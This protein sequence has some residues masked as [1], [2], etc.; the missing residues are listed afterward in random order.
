MEKTFAV[1]A[2]MLLL[3]APA[4]NAEDDV[5]AR[6]LVRAAI[7]VNALAY[8]ERG[9]A[10]NAGDPQLR[11][12]RSRFLANLGMVEEA[13]ETLQK[14]TRDHPELAE[15]YQALALLYAAQDPNGKSRAA[16]QESLSANLAAHQSAGLDTRAQ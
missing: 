14:L 3:A 16:R 7:Y 8:I 5:E 1:L 10:A 13:I 2:G 6:T 4:A 12:F 9:L 11:L 15:P